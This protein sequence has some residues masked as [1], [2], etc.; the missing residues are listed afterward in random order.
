[1]QYALCIGG[2][3]FW[4]FWIFDLLQLKID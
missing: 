2:V 3:D 4:I 1:V